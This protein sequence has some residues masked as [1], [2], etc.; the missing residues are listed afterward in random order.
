MIYWA[1]SRPAVGL[2]VSFRVLALLDCFGRPCFS[3]IANTIGW[4]SLIIFVR[5][6][7]IV[8][9]GVITKWAGCIPPSAGFGRPKSCHLSISHCENCI[10]AS[11][12]LSGFSLFQYDLYWSLSPLKTI[13][14]VLLGAASRRG[15]LGIVLLF[16]LPRR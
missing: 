11:I 9:P 10:R 13:F 7:C 16:Y 2:L 14:L 1:K 12:K 15:F 5:A 4:W 6:G 8:A 3:R